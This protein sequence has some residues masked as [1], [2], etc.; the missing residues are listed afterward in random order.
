MTTG[1][2]KKRRP[3][4]LGAAGTTS[5]LAKKTEDEDAHTEA[6]EEQ[7]QTMFQL[8]EGELSEEAEIRTIFI[9]AESAYD[10]LRGMDEDELEEDEE[11]PEE[12]R[13]KSRALKLYAGVVH[14]CDRLLK[15]HDAGEHAE[16]TP[17][18]FELM[19][20]A[21]FKLRCLESAG[22]SID[23]D[24]EYIVAAGEKYD[25]GLEEFPENPDLLYSKA[26]LAICRAILAED[27]EISVDELITS[28]IASLP[29][30]SAEAFEKNVHKLWNGLGEF[31]SLLQDSPKDLCAVCRGS[32]DIVPE[33][34]ALSFAERL[35]LASWQVKLIEATM[36]LDAIEIAAV[37]AGLER[38]EA[39][40]KEEPCEDPEAEATYGE[41]QAQL[42]LLRGSKF[43][44]QGLVK[45]EQEC[46]QAA[47]TVF[48]DLE[49]R[50]GIAVP[51]FIQELVN[52]SE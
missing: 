34:A 52:D 21:L 19:G 41:L 37:E 14:E 25:A 33:G 50:L 15:L 45:E 2:P 49:A 39:L 43:G 8:P 6:A 7:S 31:S 29:R 38:L 1:E 4:G 9:A 28:I 30:L 46:Y 12:E 51:E 24:D 48:Q 11:K 32:L 23:A 42:H 22:L 10:D 47:L 3:L 40:L 44:L 16:L 26:R 18:I 35:Q 27:G 36:E 5:K 17:E 20:D 13:V